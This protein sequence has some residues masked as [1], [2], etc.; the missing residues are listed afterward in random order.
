[1]SQRKNQKRQ[2][3]G[4]RDCPDGFMEDTILNDCIKYDYGDN[5]ITAKRNEVKALAVQ[6]ANQ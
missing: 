6:G 2:Q 3:K 5:G 4:G 1:M